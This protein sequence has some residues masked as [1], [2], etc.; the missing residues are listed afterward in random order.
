MKRG[1]PA[2][3]ALLVVL[4]AGI[5]YQG[6][7]LA[8]DSSY[9][10]ADTEDGMSSRPYDQ[11]V[12]SALRAVELNPYNYK[13][14]IGVG[15]MYLEELRG[16]AS[17]VV[18]A[19]ESGEDTAQYTESLRS[20]FTDAESAFNKAVAFAP[21]LYVNYVNLASVY[22]LAGSALDEE[23]YQRVFAVA[24]RALQAKPL[25][26]EIRMQLA[27]ALPGLERTDEAI[28]TLERCMEITPG[29]VGPALLLAD[30]YQKA[31]R[32]ADALAL[33]KSVA[34]IHPNQPDIA[35]AMRRLEAEE[36]QP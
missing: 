26:I 4:A 11:R 19:R 12:E 20:S 1:I 28:E 29:G 7:V 23:L 18:A 33:L 36:S 25:G 35:A 31:G 3:V 17:A 5:G 24:E 13:Y 22:V 21:D 30:V 8:A 10:A 2:A 32:H 34:A 9:V 14:R 27:E 6:V 15:S 16:V